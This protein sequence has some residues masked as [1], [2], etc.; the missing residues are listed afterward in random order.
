MNINDEGTIK[1]DDDDWGINDVEKEKEEITQN[2]EPITIEQMN[3]AIEEAK[4]IMIFFV[5]EQFGKDILDKVSDTINNLKIGID[6][7]PKTAKSCVAYYSS[8][9]GVY[10]TENHCR[11]KKNNIILIHTIIHEYA[12]SLSDLLSKGEVN[13]VVE[14]ALVDLF[15]EMSINNYIQKGN[16]INYISENDNDILANNNGYYE[17][18]SYISEGE[19]TRG[20]MYA[21]RTKNMDID[22][23]REYFFGSKEKFVDMCEQTLGHHLRIILTKDLSNVRNQ[24]GVKNNTTSYLPQASKELRNILANH[25]NYPLDETAIKQHK[26]GEE[27]ELYSIDGSLM[28][29]ICYENRLRYEWLQKINFSNIRRSNVQQVFSG[30]HIEDIYELSKKSNGK[31]KEICSQ[32]GYSDFIKLLIRGWYEA[33]KENSSNFEEIMSLTGGIPFDVFQEI[34]NDKEVTNTSDIMHFLAQYHVLNDEDNYSSILE[35]LNQ[36]VGNE[37]DKAQ[38]GKQV[39]NDE[40]TMF[41]L[42]ENLLEVLSKLNLSNDDL[43]RILYIYNIPL[44]QINPDNILN[45]I[46]IL[47]KIDY[48]TLSKND[49]NNLFGLENNIA[50]YIVDKAKIDDIGLLIKIGQLPHEVREEIED[51]LIFDNLDLFDD[52]GVAIST[53]KKYGYEIENEYEILDCIMSSDY[54]NIRIAPNFNVETLLAFTKE[55]D[56]TN[57][58]LSAC[59]NQFLESDSSMLF[60]DKNFDTCLM[61][62]D[63]NNQELLGISDVMT[64]RICSIIQGR[65]QNTNEINSEQ[66]N[67]LEEKIDNC[68]TGLENKNSLKILSDYFNSFEDTDNIIPNPIMFY[69]LEQK[70]SKEQ[71]EDIITFFKSAY[72]RTEDIEKGFFEYDLEN[73]CK[74]LELFE[75][76]DISIESDYYDMGQDLLIYKLMNGAR[77]V[78]IDG[79]NVEVLRQ[80]YYKLKT[81]KGLSEEDIADNLFENDE[82]KNIVCN[83]QGLIENGVSATLT[84]TRASQINYQVSQ[85]MKHQNEKVKE[86]DE[87]E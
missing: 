35:L 2:I 37:F 83:T 33:N 34:M 68:L 41:Y 43:Q 45:I 80:I 84:T 23:L 52:V 7:D 70:L 16:R 4:K 79:E 8:T 39:E 65:I 44:S 14:E 18:N 51:G 49:L 75:N 59:I 42:N 73:I 61:L 22:A 24:L 19:F 74:V 5:E 50:I 30:L 28:D 32:W 27:S 13:A 11:E 47:D 15:A 31:I 9:E 10:L 77:S 60:D 64:K 76:T 56:K 29:A 38:Y 25:I 66:R 3:E 85:I 86:L 17:Q 48:S 58:L 63:D 78:A 81:I 62:L 69:L 57:I 1:V 87:L 67:K 6:S 54:G 82:I 40:N 36:K 26:N 72:P 20:I 71:V 12:H 21:L 46:D 55:K 53:L